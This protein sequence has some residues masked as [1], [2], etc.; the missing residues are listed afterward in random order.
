[1]G[2]GTLS[3]A[4]KVVNKNINGGHWEQGWRHDLPNG[5]GVGFAMILK[6]LR[7]QGR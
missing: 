2:G 7:W 4:D 6:C 5:V 1:M 3:S